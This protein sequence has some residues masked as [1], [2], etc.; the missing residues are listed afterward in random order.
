MWGREGRVA[1]ASLL[2]YKSQNFK[3]VQ[4]FV[5]KIISWAHFVA[6]GAL[7]S[8]IISKLYGGARQA[9]W[10]LKKKTQPTYTLCF[11][12]KAVTWAWRQLKHSIG[13]KFQNNFFDLMRVFLGLK[14][15]ADHEYR[16]CFRSKS[17]DMGVAPTQTF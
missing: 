4:N 1:L 13:P 12:R 6:F 3:F 14:K 11:G 8:K 17:R 5:R 15:C 16:V 9:L 7:I 10:A 2:I